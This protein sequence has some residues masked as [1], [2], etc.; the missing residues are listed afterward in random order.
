MPPH[1]G[2][3]ALFV[4]FCLFPHSITRLV[5]VPS[6]FRATACWRSSKEGEAIRDR[7]KRTFGFEHSQD[8]LVG[9]E[10]RLQCGLAVHFAG[11][12]Y[13]MSC[14][15]RGTYWRTSPRKCE[16]HSPAWLQTPAGDRLTRL[17]YARIRSSSLLLPS[18]VQF[19]GKP[20][21]LYLG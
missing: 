4:N 5:R 6:F 16:L 21:D 18:L 11:Q 19:A 7:L 20:S 12:R 13:E 17:D 9:L 3:A 10:R 15:H 2:G 1:G 14:L 8:V